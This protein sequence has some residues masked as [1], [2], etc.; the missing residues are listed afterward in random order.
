MV[1]NEEGLLKDLQ[2]NPIASAI[3]RTEI[4]GTA[5]IMDNSMIK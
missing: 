4:V 5:I 3:T 2:Y 1:I